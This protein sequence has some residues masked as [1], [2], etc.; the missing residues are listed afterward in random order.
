MDLMNKKRRKNM[1]K[2]DKVLLT[3]E[4]AKKWF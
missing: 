4:Q 3:K 2:K 1:V